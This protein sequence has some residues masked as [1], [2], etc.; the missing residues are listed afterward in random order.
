LHEVV[1]RAG[2]RVEH[3]LE[4]PLPLSVHRFFATT[5]SARIRATSKWALRAAAHGL[6]PSLARR[7]FTVH[8][9]C[10]CLPDA[11]SR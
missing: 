3:E 10:I 4:D 7:L 5:R 6:A 9:A 1:R 2:L 11:A 8:Y